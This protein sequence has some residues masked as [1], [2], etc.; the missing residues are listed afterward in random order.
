LILDSER[1]LVLYF[2]SIEWPLY[3]GDIEAFRNDWIEIDID[4]G[5]FTSKSSPN[6]LSD[7][8]PELPEFLDRTMDRFR[9]REA[10]LQVTLI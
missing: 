7:D 9:E 10:M 8:H 5:R 4:T 6:L 2:I 3:Y 1:E